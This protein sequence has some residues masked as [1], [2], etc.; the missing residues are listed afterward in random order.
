MNCFGKNQGLVLSFNHC[1]SQKCMF[2]SVFFLGGGMTFFFVKSMFC[3]LIGQIPS[4]SLV[5]FEGGDSDHVLLSIGLVINGAKRRL[6]GNS[7]F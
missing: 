1:F 7:I 6:G 4:C 5:C 3:L 2:P